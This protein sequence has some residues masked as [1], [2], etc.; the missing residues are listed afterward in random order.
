MCTFCYSDSVSLK[1]SN[2]STYSSQSAALSGLFSLGQQY[3]WSSVG[4]G[5][6]DILRGPAE[7]PFA[8]I[9]DRTLVNSSSASADYFSLSSLRFPAAGQPQPPQQHNLG[10]P[11][12]QSLNPFGPVATKP[13]ILNN[14]F[15]DPPPALPTRYSQPPQK[16]PSYNQG[17]Q[18]SPLAQQSSASPGTS[19]LNEWQEG[20]KA[21]LPNVNVRF[22]PELNSAG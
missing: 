1:L 3:G 15:T 20:L 8:P 14:Q 13:P 17:S 2:C 11:P 19:Q 12:H 9:P 21:L 7:N 16:Y 6:N 18:S 22:V 5:A 10:A 4:G